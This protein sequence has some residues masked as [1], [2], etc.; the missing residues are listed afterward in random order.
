MTKVLAAGVVENLM[1]E[2][3]EGKTYKLASLTVDGKFF[4]GIFKRPQ[5][6]SNGMNVQII[7]HPAA[8]GRKYPEKEIV[9][10]AGAPAPAANNPSQPS[11]SPATQDVISRQWAVSQ[12]IQF[13]TLLADKGAIPAKAL[14]DKTGTLLTAMV[15]QYA[16]LWFNTVQ[17]GVAFEKLPQFTGMV[18]EEQVGEENND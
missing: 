10:A 18:N 7:E 13:V 8:A 14:N 16:N 6:L 11:R 1:L 4:K 17:T 9:L 2:P 5:G 12:A 15:G 3:V